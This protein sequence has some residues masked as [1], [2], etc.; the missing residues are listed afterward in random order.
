MSTTTK[1]LPDKPS[2]LLRLAVRDLEATEADENY[3]VSM[4]ALW[5]PGMKPD[6]RPCLVCFAGA[7]MAKT[8]GVDIFS[9][10]RPDNFEPII[11]RQLLA[12]NEARLYAW[13]EFLR[14]LDVFQCNEDTL[15]AR[16]EVLRKLEIQ[17]FDNG[18]IEYH[19]SPA[20]F[21]AN[22]LAAADL[23]EKEGF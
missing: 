13:Y 15:P 8:L 11:N 23:L 5:H 14:H 3:E 4:E 2:D 17:R 19:I 9:G 7:T 22:M 16:L 18:A 12:L 20:G 1:T 6:L 21:K 10:L